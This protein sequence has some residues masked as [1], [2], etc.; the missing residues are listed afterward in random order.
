LQYAFGRRGDLRASSAN[1]RRSFKKLNQM[2]DE[3]STPRILMIAG[4]NG[5]GKTTVTPRILKS[6]YDIAEWVNADVIARG[7]SGLQP[8]AAAW[9]AGRV[10]IDRL[11]ELTE[12][13]KSF[14]FETTLAGRSYAKW[15]E[16]L[17]ISGYEFHL[18][19]VTVESADMCVA[20][21]ARRVRAGGHHVPD[22][23]VRRRYSAR[24]GI[25][26]TFIDRLPM[27]DCL[28]QFAGGWTVL[29]ATG[30]YNDTMVVADQRV[31]DRLEE[32]LR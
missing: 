31:W 2:S 5:A 32:N 24:C 19:Y 20:R 17:L 23:V 12:Q 4:P 25:S 29:V 3:S 16:P 10:M 14:A 28:R 21:V 9:Q 26:L 18:Y 6:A 13:R 30:A 22:D 27:L 15:I 1:Q 8:E 7:L 11:R